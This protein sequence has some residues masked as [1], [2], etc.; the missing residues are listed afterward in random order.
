MNYIFNMSK[1]TVQVRV[2]PVL[3][4]YNAAIIVG[5]GTLVDVTHRSRGPWLCHR[6]RGPAAPQS[7]PVASENP[8]GWNHGLWVSCRDGP[9]AAFSSVHQGQNNFCCLRSMA[10]RRGRPLVSK[11]C[12]NSVLGLR[13]ITQHVCGDDSTPW[14]PPHEEVR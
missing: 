12:K 5:I 9:G 4:S 11:S 1:A 10:E 7:W 14:F 13:W 8:K 6:Q 2:N 3:M